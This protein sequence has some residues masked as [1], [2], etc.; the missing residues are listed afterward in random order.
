M[1]SRAPEN[2]GG[3][4]CGRWRPGPTRVG[5][6]G[7]SQRPAVCRTTGLAHGARQ[8]PLASRQHS[9]RPRDLSV[10]SSA[11][12]RYASPSQPVTPT[13]GRPNGS[14]HHRPRPA[15]RGHRPQYLRGVRRAPR[16]VCLR[17]RLRAGLSAGRPGRPADRRA[18]GVAAAAYSNIRYPG[19]NFVSAYRW[20][21]GVGPVEDRPVRSDPAWHATDP[22]TFGTDE[23]I[24][25]CR[26]LGAEPYFVVNAATVTC[27]KRVTGWSTATARRPRR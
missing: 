4:G 2:P 7:E 11:W 1:G 14:H 8:G 16:P 23:F 9:E 18:G 3:P 26:A 12:Q 27:A 22:N 25:F 6:I 21:D 19:G 17:R 15:D 20:R 10:Q 5:H 24:G 13:G